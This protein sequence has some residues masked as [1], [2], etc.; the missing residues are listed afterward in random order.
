VGIIEQ[1]A[2]MHAAVRRRDHR[3]EQQLPGVVLVPQEILRVES[4]LGLST[5][6]ICN[7]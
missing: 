2:H 7:K 3:L 1:Q 4:P 6:C 5:I